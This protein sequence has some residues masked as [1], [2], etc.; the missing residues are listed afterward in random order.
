MWPT[1]PLTAWLACAGPGPSASDTQAAGTDSAWPELPELESAALTLVHQGLRLSS[2]ETLAV[3]TAPAGLDQPQTLSFVLT[4]RS[5]QRLEFD[6]DP[7]AWLD[8]DT[9]SWVE[10]PPQGLDP[11]QSAAFT[12][13]LSVQG[14]SSGGQRT[15]TLRV[16]SSQV[17]FSLDLALQVPE[18]LRLVVVGNGGWLAVSHDYGQ[19]FQDLDYDVDDPRSRTTI[20]YG[21]GR[22]F[23]AWA[24]TNDW[25]EPGRY[26]YSEDLETW[27]SATVN[28]DFWASHCLYAHSQFVCAWDGG[29][30]WSESGAGVIH[31]PTWGGLLNRAAWD[32]QT[33]QVVFAGRSSRVATS[34]DGQVFDSDQQVSP[35]GD[36]FYSV[37]VGGDTWV[38]VGG[39]NRDLVATSHDQGATWSVQLLR[40][41]QYLYLTDVAY[42]DG[43]WLA[44]SMD[45]SLYSSAD[46]D[47]WTALSPNVGSLEILGVV[48]DNFLAASTPW[49]AQS[50]LHLSPDGETWTQVHSVP[51]TL[52][53]TDMALETWE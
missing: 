34:S 7:A 43:L 16:P 12:L 3:H 13:E 45:G 11:D 36:T 31:E 8:S 4:N 17:D 52:V 18:P 32:A 26:A 53:P 22:F 9:L 19:S 6:A 28:D 39:S 49:Q 30:A 2:G 25:S 44:A 37:A 1:L 40:E 21:G 15:E 24:D 10:P 20:A 41:Q 27:Q 47:G 38:A 23:K 48:G 46:G 14:W 35:D 50:T 33:Q 51:G 5:A 42:K 29:I